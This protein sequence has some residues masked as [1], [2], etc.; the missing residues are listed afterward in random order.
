MSELQDPYE[1]PV[2]RAAELECSE[3][4][5]RWLVEGLWAWAGVGLIG[6]APKC[7]KSWLGLDMA[8]SIASGTA[9][10]NTF[11]VTS[12]GP[13]LV[14]L[15]E[16]SAAVVRSR[17]AGLCRLR[18]VDFKE[19]PLDVITAPAVRLD[20]EKDQ[21]RLAETVRRLRPRLLLLDPFV[22]LHRIDE[23]SA[24]EVS[25]L[26]AYLR[27]LQRELELAI[28]IVH[29]VR[30]SGPGGLQAGQALRGSGDFH[31]WGDSNLYLRRQR[32]GLTLTI[33]HRAAPSPAPLTLSLLAGEDH[34]EP[35]L[36]LAD[37]TP[38][39][40]PEQRT[41]QLDAAVLKALSHAT[42]PVSRS[43]LRATLRVR[44]ESLGD[45]LARLADAGQVVRHGD[46]WALPA[47]AVPVPTP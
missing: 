5:S 44:N 31:A 39:T 26:L 6:G 9:C 17:L 33:E 21:R 29:H 40:S 15:A 18:Q 3:A 35:H 19:L 41:E 37:A 13:T 47:S 14:Y 28:I 45:T 22:R 11:P 8:L 12:P 38:A 24:A 20:L 25:A 27:E 7:C 30:K 4:G 34:P 46:R 10:L 43:H 36:A 23:N 32:D 1:L 16:D 2:V 42:E